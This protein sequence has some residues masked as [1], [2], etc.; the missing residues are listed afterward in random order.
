MCDPQVAEAFF[1]GAIA[2]AACMTG[3]GLTLVFWA[4]AD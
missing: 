4:R 1:W 2:G 3:I